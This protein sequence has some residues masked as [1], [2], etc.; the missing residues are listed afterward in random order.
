MH[1]EGPRGGGEESRAQQEGEGSHPPKCPSRDT[2]GVTQGVGK[3]PRSRGS[4]A[5]QGCQTGPCRAP[6]HGAP[7]PALRP[8]LLSP[9]APPQPVDW[10]QIN[11]GKVCWAP[12]ASKCHPPP[13]AWPTPVQ[14][15]SPDF[16]ADSGCFIPAPHPDGTRGPG[17]RTVGSDPTS[18][19]QGSRPSLKCAQRT[20]STRRCRS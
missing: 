2:T 13:R 3:V 19:C 1:R 11:K 8:M 18:V 12:S 6:T 16:L 4:P 7:S 10:S 9:P 20:P 17:E 14:A 5:E 15:S